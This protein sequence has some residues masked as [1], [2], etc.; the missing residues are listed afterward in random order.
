FLDRLAR[1]LVPGTSDAGSV[2]VL[3]LDL[4]RFK[5]VNDSLGHAAGDRL[6]VE[7]ARR[8]EGCVRPADTVARLGGDEFTILL[9]GL[10]DVAEALAVAERITRAYQAPF[11]LGGG[12]LH[13]AVSVGIALSIREG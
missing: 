11:A 7:T 13:T 9:E 1:A 8:L 12:P 2:A 3:C 5:H 4:D 6:L 10:T